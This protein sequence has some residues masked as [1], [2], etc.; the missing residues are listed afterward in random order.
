MTKES[1]HQIGA[2]FDV[3]K[4]IVDY[5][6]MSGYYWYFH[7]NLYK[8]APPLKRTVAGLA[9]M[10]RVTGTYLNLLRCAMKKDDRMT[11]NRHYYAALSGIDAGLYGSLID[12]WYREAGILEKIY[13]Q[14]G[15]VIR[16]HQRQGH[17]VVLV[18]GS[19]LPL[20]EPLGKALQVDE[21]L[22]TEVEVKG[23]VFTGKIRNELPMVG[24]GKARAI[25]RYAQRNGIDLSSSYAYSDHISDLKMLETV[26]NPCAV[27][28]DMKLDEYARKRS[29]QIITTGC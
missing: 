4:T 25:R 21:I 1:K 14:V 2:F 18:S 8:G 3:D 28:G 20:I 17:R 15:T 19:H 24:E 12:E 11:V 29:W 7:R 6:T 13:G 23:T 9:H 16:N 10:V 22:A 5:N 26:G 27:I